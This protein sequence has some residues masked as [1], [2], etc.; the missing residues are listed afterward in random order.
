MY[1][2][3]SISSGAKCFSGIY[4][5]ALQL[6]P[7]VLIHFSCLFY[8]TKPFVSPCFMSYVFC[9][10]Q[11]PNTNSLR[12]PFESLHICCFDSVKELE[13]CKVSCV[14]CTECPTNEVVVDVINRI[15]AALFKAKRTKLNFG[16]AALVAYAFWN[17]RCFAHQKAWHL[18]QQDTLYKGKWKNHNQN[19]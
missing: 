10:R 8:L 17:Q 16:Y 7:E 1:L 9:H 3:I 12:W 18:H 11:L 19:Y 14:R 4:S 13:L 2:H 15:V 5:I 6:F